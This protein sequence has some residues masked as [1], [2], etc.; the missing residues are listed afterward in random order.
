[1]TRRRGGRAPSPPRRLRLGALFNA[2][3]LSACHHSA[4][5]TTLPTLPARSSVEQLQDTIDAVL[6][7]PALT[8][9]TWGVAV[10]S[11]ARG[12][13]LYAHNSGK[14]MIPAS[15]M[16]LVTLAAAAERL[17]W[18][19]SYDTRVVAV[20]T[21]D[22][23]LLD[24]ELVVVGSG[25][26]SLDDWDGAATRTFESWV[27]RL[28]DAGVRAVSGQVV[29]DDN[30]FD[31]NALG[32]GWAW[33]DLAASYA[34]G[35]GALQFNENT[36]QVTVA[37]GTTP[38]EPAIV[39][40]APLSASLTLR[41][42]ATTTGPE[43]PAAVSVRP[44]PHER[45]IEVRGAVPVSSGSVTRNVSVGNATAYF[46]GALQDALAAGGIDVRGGV[47]DI[48]D[49]P[50]PPRTAGGI[51]LV[52]HQSPPLSTLATTMMKLSQNLY[53]ETLL[54][55]LGGATS[56]VGS[57]QAGRAAVVEALN[58]WNIPPD[59]VIQADGS[60]LSRYNMAT[61]RALVRVLA[62][63][64]DDDRLR[65]PFMDALPVAG[66]D[67]TL[68]ERTRGTPAAGNIRAK[69]G[70]LSNA[71]AVAGYVTTADGEPLAF[72]IL[73]NHYG[74]P[75]TVVDEATDRILVTLAQYSRR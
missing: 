37:P 75:A 52:L 27:E 4:P 11:L 21:I 40:A 61:P 30:A 63:V 71:R 1:M 45:A 24:G 12:D 73:A 51:A 8:R 59:E 65:A 7:S 58:A 16:K 23:G 18:D 62:H 47:A 17:G 55:T 15:T 54:R 39:S 70:S 10:Q 72:A 14:L 26:P 42:L 19:Y 34:T 28:K 60:G 67:G 31:D 49:L 35:V 9:G 44:V 46:L 53:A 64:Y 68:A 36:A 13:T 43:L 33:D 20:G 22:R 74:T 29:G 66:V 50:V 32:T 38:G 48:D 41:N 69:T 5:P 2:L 25:D 56:G 6:A 57:A 3:L